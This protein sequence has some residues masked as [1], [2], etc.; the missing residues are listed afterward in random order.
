MTGFME[1]RDDDFEWEQKRG[2]SRKPKE[3]KASANGK[4]CSSYFGW[5]IAGLALALLVVMFFDSFQ[6]YVKY[7][8]LV[9]EGVSTTGVVTGKDSRRT[10]GLITRGG[11]NSDYYITYQYTALMDGSPTPFET[12]KS[13]SSFNYPKFSVGAEIEVVYLP[14]SPEV[15]APK[16][17]LEPPSIS[18]ILFFVAIAAFLAYLGLNGMFK[19]PGAR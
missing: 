8:Q 19:S 16:M 6:D 17:G 10:S 18:G 1:D 5:T 4:G 9:R 13:V 12:R 7:A 15:S 3:R 2:K 14:S 11:G